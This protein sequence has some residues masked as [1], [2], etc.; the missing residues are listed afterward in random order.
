VGHEFGNQAGAGGGCCA[1][2][3][4]LVGSTINEAKV[5]VRTITWSK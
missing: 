5:K 2:V 4:G 1:G 3:T